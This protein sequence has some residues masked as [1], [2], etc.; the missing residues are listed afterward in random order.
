MI[1]KRLKDKGSLREVIETLDIKS[2]VVLVKPNWVGAFPGGYTDAKVIDSLLSALVNHKVIFVESYTFWRTDK[3]LNKWED[4]FSSKE[5]TIDTG[6][7]H[8]NFFKKMDDWF[9]KKTGIGEVLNKHNAKYISITD[10]I[11]KGGG[12]KPATISS[13]VEKEY[14]PVA[15]KKMYEMV[16]KSLFELKGASIISFAKA[17]IDSAYGGSFSI[18][19]M[20]GLIPDPDRYTPYHGE[21]TGEVLA[22]SIIDAHKIY[23]SLFDMKFIVES[24]FEYSEMDWDTGKSRKIE[25]DG[26]IIAGQNGFEV[27]RAAENYYQAKISGPLQNLLSSYNQAFK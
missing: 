26:H 13:S 9:L 25:G 23:R 15:I 1:A 6:K 20:F 17:K 3:K 11:W 24:V 12:V 5:A 2:D 4:Y 18:K 7:Q 16:P 21:D 10:E 19:N 14:E 27:D 8:W 22:R